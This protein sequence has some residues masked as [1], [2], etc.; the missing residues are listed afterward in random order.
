MIIGVPPHGKMEVPIT[1]LTHIDRGVGAAGGG[2]R[3]TTTSRCSCSSALDASSSSTSSCPRP[4]HDESFSEVVEDMHAGRLGRVPHVLM[5]AGASRWTSTSEARPGAEQYLPRSAGKVAIVTGAGSGIGQATAKRSPRRGQGACVD[6]LAETA[7][8]TAAS[9]TEAGGTAVDL[10]CDV[11]SS[12]RSRFTVA[13]TFAEFGR[14]DALCNIAG[15]GTFLNSHEMDLAQF[16]K[17][18]AVNLNGSRT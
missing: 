14:I 18:V 6:L 7:E 10:A 12:S 13:A 2:A 3:P 9:V 17:I 1:H 5:A 4:T 8:A 16:D 11:S 15:I